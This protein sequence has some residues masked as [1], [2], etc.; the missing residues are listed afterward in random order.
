MS[1]SN[2][3]ATFF[4]KEELIGLFFFGLVMV[5]FIIRIVNTSFPLQISHFKKILFT[6]AVFVISVVLLICSRIYN[7][8]WLSIV[9]C[10][11]TG[12]ATSFGDSTIVGFIKA[13]NPDFF[14]G[15]SSGTG[16]SGFLGALYFLLLKFF[17]VSLVYILISLLLVYHLYSLSFYLVLRM[18]TQMQNEEIDTL[19]NQGE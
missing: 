16:M 2:E 11:T 9:A 4:K 13:L 15:Y 6:T 5:D 8:F 17:D 18:K 10:V 3:M 12:L 1:L 14:S 7:A 19:D